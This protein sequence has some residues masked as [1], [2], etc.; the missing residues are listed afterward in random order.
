MAK[1]KISGVWKD[2]NNVITHY[3][4]HA[5]NENVTLKA[6]K[7]SKENA[8]SLLETSENSAVTLI[9]NYSRAGWDVGESVQ[10]VNG[11]NGKF[12]RS[13]PGNSL[14]DDL[15]HLVDFDWIDQNL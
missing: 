4:L 13:N 12:L 7:I 6:S 5:E 2:E 3:A 15:G 11:A 8:I 9:W 14:T 10:V 1:H